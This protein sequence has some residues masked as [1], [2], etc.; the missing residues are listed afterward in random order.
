MGLR[1][2]FLDSWTL[3]FN[4]EAEI[5]A[6]P[7]WVRFP[8][9]PLH[10]WGKS[11][12]MD[13]GNKLGCYL[14]SADPKGGQFRCSRICVEVKLEKGLSKALKLTLR[15]WSHIQ[16]LDYEQ[17]PFKCNFC[18]VYG[19]FAKSCPKLAESQKTT[20]PPAPKD[21]EFQTV[22]SRRRPPRRKEPQAS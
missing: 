17:I 6:V 20:T 12:L 21:T 13:I 1:G 22:I 9:L 3:G 5:T 14:D 2:L 4:P 8:N 16:E 19:H 11:T 10:L 18:H 15:D 7:V